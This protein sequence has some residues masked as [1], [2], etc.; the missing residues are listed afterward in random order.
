MNA[1]E[2]K[3]LNVSLGDFRLEDINITLPKGC[4]I[5][6][7]GENG[8]GKT[9]LIETMLGIHKKDSGTVEILG[10]DH[11]DINIRNDIGVV[12]DSNVFEDEYSVGALCEM[13]GSFYKN[14][15]DEKFYSYLEQYEIHKHSSVGSLSKG[16]QMKVN[17][18]AAIAHDPKLL[19]LDEPTSGLDPIAR[20]EFNSLLLDFTH[21]EERSIMI[22]SHITTDLDKICDY[23]VFMHKGRVVLCGEKDQLCEN[24]CVINCSDEELTRLPEDKILYKDVTNYGTRVYIRTEAVPEGYTMY[25]LNIEDLYIAIVKEVE[26]K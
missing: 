14:W 22:S 11:T 25:K 8:A 13:L 7:V 24:Y 18:A 12:Y 1:F 4:I 3:G 23:I 15:S 5:G 21:D 26:K 10:K 19:I 2:I 9:T 16:M 20:N 17:I 6:L